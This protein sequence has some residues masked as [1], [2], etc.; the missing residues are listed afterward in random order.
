MYWV[1]AGRH[2]VGAESDADANEITLGVVDF[3]YMVVRCFSLA[4]WQ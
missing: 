4:P 1:S 3:R 2:S